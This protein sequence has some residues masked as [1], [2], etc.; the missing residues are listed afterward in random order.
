MVT[1]FDVAR[2]AGVSKSTV[3]SVLNHD[4]RVKEET[5]ILVEDAIKQLGYVG[6]Q[7]ARGLRKR[8]NKAIGIV[9]AVDKRPD[10]MHFRESDNG[11]FIY[12]VSNGII[13]MLAG[14]GYSVVTERYNVTESELEVPWLVKTGRVDGIVLVGGLFQKDTIEKIREYGIPMVGAGVIYENIATVNP[15]VTQGVHLVTDQL[16]RQGCRNVALLNVPERYAAYAGR[17][18]GFYQALANYRELQPRSVQVHAPVISSIGGYSAMKALWEQQDRPDGV[19]IAA[20]GMGC[21]AIRYLTEQGIRIPRDIRV[22][23]LGASHIYTALGVETVNTNNEQ[24]GRVA[25]K[26]LLKR[27]REGE[28]PV[29]HRIVDMMLHSDSWKE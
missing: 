7:N 20:E 21:G 29:E 25:G 6:N 18:H 12:A 8:E 16:L 11:H 9:V 13:D 3:S 10:D 24:V 19:V 23:M 1:I 14:S 4:P 22:A 17:S 5:R 2:Y 28:A 27:I 15:N 26:M